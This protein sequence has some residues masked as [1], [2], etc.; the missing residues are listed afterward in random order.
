MTLC[1]KERDVGNP[2]SALLK[3]ACRAAAELPVPAVEEPPEA[4]LASIPEPCNKLL[5][6][7]SSPPFADAGPEELP[8]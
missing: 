3:N 7:V 8:S 1:P 2:D 4:S 6:E 5:N